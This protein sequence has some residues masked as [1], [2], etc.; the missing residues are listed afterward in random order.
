MTPVFLDGRTQR[1]HTR[2]VADVVVVGSG[3]AGS[4]V[5][6]ALARQ[7][8]KVLVVEEGDRAP[9]E[10]FRPDALHAMTAHYRQMGATLTSGRRPQP[11]VQGRAL[12]GG[13]V[14]NGAIAWW[15]PT[16][17]L[18][19]WLDADP[20]LGSHWTHPDLQAAQD[21]IATRL[22]VAP[23]DP[24]IAGRHNAL[25]AA[26][27]EALGVDHR[28]TFRFVRGCEGLGRCLQG[29]PKGRKTSMDLTLL[30]DAA[31][32][33][34]RLTTGL[35]AHKLVLQRG[36]AVGVA[37][38]TA[39]GARVGIRARHGVVLAASAIQTPR[40]L[41]RSGLGGDHVGTGFACHPGAGVLGR[42]PDPVNCWTGATQGHEVTGWRHE[43]IKLEV[44]GLDRGVLTSRLPGLGTDWA[45]YAAQA[46]HYASLGVAIK[47]AARGRVG[48]G[49]LGG[50][51]VRFD[52]L[53]QDQLTLLKGITRAAEVLFAA[54]AQAVL[55]GVP[56][57]P[58]ALHRVDALHALLRDPP[59]RLPRPSTVATHLFGTCRAASHPDHGVVRPDLRHWQV[60]GLW[61]ADSSVFP[62]NTGV[63]PQ[64]SIMGVAAICAASAGRR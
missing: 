21:A 15:L 56:G 39:A 58:D 10:G 44:L 17:V 8:V 4:V 37:C 60:D 29:C 62:G 50:T 57:L 45:A 18:R 24:A 54:G 5:A 55:P 20:G 30:A 46:S 59:R 31:T 14:I 7:G 3:P 36:R 32:H 61:V 2:L 6:D 26:G 12:G 27:A 1:S 11:I 25:I 41:Q 43:G 23:T 48:P 9:N 49:W 40:L 63:N 35:T 42:F 34:A 28:P 22:G 38:T 51:R 19:S 16:D 13:S 52:L 47:A 64:L 53:P 33:G